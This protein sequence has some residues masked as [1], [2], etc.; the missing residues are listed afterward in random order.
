MKNYRVGIFEEQGGYITI[1]AENEE[2]AEERVIEG[3]GIDGVNFFKDFD[4]THRNT[5]ITD[6]PKRL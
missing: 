4:C 5:E 6:S 3:L 1:Q 2:E